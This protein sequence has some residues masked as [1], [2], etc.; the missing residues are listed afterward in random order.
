MS[1]EGGRIT[2]D[3]IEARFRELNGEVTTEVVSVRSQALTIAAGVAV[4]VIAIA[5]L[6]GRRGGRKRSTVVEVRRI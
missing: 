6:A 5:F 4:V 2:R 3:D 1:P